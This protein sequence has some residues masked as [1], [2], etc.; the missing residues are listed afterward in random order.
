MRTKKS[1]AELIREVGKVIL[2][3]H[4]GAMDFP[5]LY[6]LIK[7]KLEKIALRT[8]F[9]MNSFT[10]PIGGFEIH[11]DGDT[12]I[13]ALKDKF[14]RKEE[15]KM[16][17][18]PN[19]KK[20]TTLQFIERAIKNLGKNGNL[21]TVYSGFNDAFRTYFEGKDPVEEVQKLAKEGKISLRPS[22]KGTPGA[23][24]SLIV[25]PSAAE[26]ALKKMGLL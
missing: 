10:T 2:E 5:E 4:G 8:D 11:A 12:T 23:V 1:T 17:M 20:L 24:I 9:I 25:V 21:H 6:R 3:K 18:E 13:V 26:K 14:S 7:E 15:K 19:Q 22:K 16:V